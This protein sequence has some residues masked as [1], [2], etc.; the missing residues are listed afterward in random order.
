[1]LATSRFELTLLYDGGCPLCLREIVFLQKRDREGKILFV[2]ID[3]K[4]YDSK[5][6]KGISYR[7]AMERIHAVRHD[8]TILR[9]VEVFR[10]SYEL[11]G[12]GWL[13]APSSWP[14]LKPLINIGYSLWTKLRFKLTGRPSL[15]VLC[16]ERC[17][18]CNE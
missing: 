3:S 7:D 9:D 14:I 1:M 11:V 15:D 18:S 16:S 4:E 6:Y 2:N 12:I 8:G 10:E 13:Y 17:S 5:L